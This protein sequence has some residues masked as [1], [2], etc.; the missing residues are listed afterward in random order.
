MT[1]LYIQKYFRTYFMHNIIK[2]FS[3]NFKIILDLNFLE[4]RFQ[5]TL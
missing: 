4:Y 5:F 3:L 2:N 1:Y